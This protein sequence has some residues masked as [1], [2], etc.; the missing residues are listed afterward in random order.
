[1][2]PLHSILKNQNKIA[3]S[4][5]SYSLLPG[6]GA[7]DRSPLILCMPAP[8]CYSMAWVATC[9][10]Q[11]YVVPW[12]KKTFLN[13]VKMNNENRQLKKTIAKIKRETEEAKQKRLIEEENYR[14]AIIRLNEERLIAR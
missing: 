14:I 9:I 3:I 4:L 1:M 2:P 8:F 10:V 6:Y 13:F 12:C 11:S 7:P 5:L